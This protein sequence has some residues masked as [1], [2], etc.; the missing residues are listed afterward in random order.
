MGEYSSIGEEARRGWLGVPDS[1]V[2]GGREMEEWSVEYTILRVD[3]TFWWVRK[4]G[5][6]YVK[7]RGE[8][9]K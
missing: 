4:R 2:G 8:G 5:R 6:E 7:K 9:V 3:T 1:D